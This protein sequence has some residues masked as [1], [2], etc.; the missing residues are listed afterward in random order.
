M[1]GDGAF[2]ELGR[3]AIAT[4]QLTELG[5]RP[6]VGWI[7]RDPDPDV[8]E[9]V[10]VA[11][12]A[13]PK[14]HRQVVEH[15]LHDRTGRDGSEVAVVERR[16]RPVEGTE[17]GFA[18]GGGD[19]SALVVGV[20][21][22]VRVVALADQEVA[23]HADADEVEIEAPAD[24]DDHHRQRDRHADA[25]AQDLVEIAVA[26]VVVVVAVAREPLAHEEVA[27]ER[28][29]G[30]VGTRGGDLVEGVEPDRDIGRGTRSGR[31][32]QEQRLVE[33]DLVAV[34]QQGG[35]TIGGGHGPTVANYGGR[36]SSRHPYLSTGHPI[37]FA[38][39]GGA[40]EHPENTERAFRHALELGYTHIETDVHVTRDGVAVAFH[41]ERLDRVTDA[42]GAIAELPWSEVAQARVDGTEPIMRLDQ[43]F[44]TFPDA[45]INLDPKHGAA[46]DPLAA[47]IVATGAVDRVMVG[48][49][50]DAR[51]AEVRRRVGERLAVSAGPRLTARLVAQSRGLR[52]RAEWVHAAQVPVRMRGVPL[53][54]RRFVEHLHRRDMQ[55]HV[56]T[57]NDAEEM[58]RLLDLGVDGIMT[59]RTAVLRDV[60]RA[61]GVWP[62][63]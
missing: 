36:V 59:D 43:L 63:P 24:L 22:T 8:E 20:D 39:R 38:H 51:I 32:E 34:S 57:V 7:G 55:V 23:R 37:A 29:D 58:H 14:A 13:G 61:R 17:P 15:A 10:E 45:C 16:I 62:G 54:T 28:V 40:S 35:Q 44:E 56:W 4:S 52:A 5:Q 26:G 48:S 27:D 53:V 42:T 33:F 25:P 46:V 21:E 11:G 50:S 30:A 41:D 2:E 12:T 47:T 18:C 60:M 31:G 1:L 19:P 9:P 49:F 3:V 6:Q